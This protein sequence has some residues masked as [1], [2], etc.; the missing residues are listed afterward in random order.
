MKQAV[1][2]R[3]YLEVVNVIRREPGAG[4]HVM[5]LQDLVQ[6]DAVEEAA[7][8]KPE[9]HA[10][11][12][13]KAGLFLGFTHRAR[14]FGNSLAI[15]LSLDEPLDVGPNTVSIRSL[16]PARLRFWQVG[17]GCGIKVQPS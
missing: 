5:P 16:F 10:C 11:C 2:Q 9:Q 7:E 3:V 4:E 1:P 15:S 6:H 17:R 14:S 8:P 12:N 13:W